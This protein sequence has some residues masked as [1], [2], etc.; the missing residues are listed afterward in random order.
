MKL[1]I[2]LDVTFQRQ[3]P[4]KQREAVNKRKTAINDEQWG[5]V[6]SF[7]F[8]GSTFTLF[9]T[10]N[11]GRLQL[12]CVSLCHGVIVI[13]IYETFFV[14]NISPFDILFIYSRMSYSEL[15]WPIAQDVFLFSFV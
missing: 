8:F 10:A 9:C 12:H 7:Y 14:I 11:N 1:V 5:N 15:R 13:I 3:D 6:K 4:I 2:S